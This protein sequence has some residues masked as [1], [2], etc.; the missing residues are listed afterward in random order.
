MS[1]NFV[2]CCVVAALFAFASPPALA[3]ELTQSLTNFDQ[4][5]LLATGGVS[6]I[7]GEGGGG[8]VPWALITGYGTRDGVGINIHHTYVGL[9]DYQLVSPGI[10]VGLFDRLE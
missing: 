1:R 6:A 4:G 10:A 2:P 3:E 5:K 8:L 7:E 9:P